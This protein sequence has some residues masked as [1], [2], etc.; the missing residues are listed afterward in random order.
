MGGS[1]LAPETLAAS[2]PRADGPRLVVLDTTHPTAIRRAMAELDP[3]RTFFIVSTKS[4]TTTETL[5]LFRIFHRDAERA[6][7]VGRAGD[8]FAAITDP[9]SPLVALASERGFRRV[10]LN[11]P[12][13]GGRYS[14]LSL[15]GLVPAA[16]AGLDLEALLDSG[17]AMAES[18]APSVSVDQNP[19]ARI[20]ALLAA[21][22]DD[23]RDKATF[24][25]P[26]SLV[27]FG[28]W[29]EQLI[30]ESTGKQGTGVVPV[31]GEPI[32]RPS[33]YGDDRLFFVLGAGPET[34]EPAVRVAFAGAEALGGQFFLWEF[35]T[36]LLGHFLRVNP[37]DQP[38]VEA[39]KRGARDI[40]AAY[41]ERGEMPEAQLATLSQI[42]RAHV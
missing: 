21:A 32:A 19:A 26:D 34:P 11:D 25:L 2:F 36:A 6:L 38:D 13:L 10:F 41:R 14:A 8:R 1:S 23:G 24:S 37:F 12:T 39:A 35:A 33:A 27:R 5:S 30:A 31:V 4:G 42:G 15:V 3:R 17:E 16:L 7:G 22:V 29:L 28:D 9:G 18:C 20:A 40:L